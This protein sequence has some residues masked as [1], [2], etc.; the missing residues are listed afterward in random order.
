[1]PYLSSLSVVSDYY[2]HKLSAT[3]PSGGGLSSLDD[4]PGALRHFFRQ[5]RLS[6]ADITRVKHSRPACAGSFRRSR[7]VTRFFVCQPTAF[8]LTAYSGGVSGGRTNFT[9][10]FTIESGSR[11][12]QLSRPSS[13]GEHLYVHRAVPATEL[14]NRGQCL[15]SE[16]DV[17][18]LAR[19]SHSSKK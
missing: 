11:E 12:L 14:W 1:M 18:S 4:S 3:P 2:T 6:S 19:P 13:L 15:T 9:T 10:N 16:T 5:R 17:G 8:R 7:L